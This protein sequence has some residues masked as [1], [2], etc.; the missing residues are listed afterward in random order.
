VTTEEARRIVIN[1]MADIAPEIDPDTLDP[2]RNLQRT[3]DLD[4]MDMLN[5][6][7]QI[8]EQAGID[9]PEADTAGLDTLDGLVAYLR[10][11]A[12]SPAG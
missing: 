12:P 6:M 11:R 4:S 5:L 10:N 8:A 7:E 1:A 9:I 2:A 3:A